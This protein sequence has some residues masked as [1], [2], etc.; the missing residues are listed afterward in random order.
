MRQYVG[1]AACRIRTDHAPRTLATLRKVTLHLLR[2]DT[3]AKGGVQARR[4]M[5]GWND[6]YWPLV[7]AGL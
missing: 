6:D 7:L 2:Q 3:Q 1:E 4:K 5:T